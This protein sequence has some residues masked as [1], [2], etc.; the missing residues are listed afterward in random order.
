MDELLKEM[1]KETPDEDVINGL[2]C[3]LFITSGGGINLAQVNEFE[4]Y[5]PCKIYPVEKDSFGW[6]IGG[7]DYNDKNFTFG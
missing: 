3:S 6:L 4:K 1:Q 5:A 2:A 7:I